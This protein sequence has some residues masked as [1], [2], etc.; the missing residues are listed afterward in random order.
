[1]AG[2]SCQ[3][4]GMPSGMYPLC[5]EHLI[6]KSAGKVIKDKG[7]KWKMQEIIE[8][9]ICI[10]CEN[11]AYGKPLCVD[12][13]KESMDRRDEFDKNQKSYELRDYYFNLRSSIYRITNFE[14]IK[15]N[16]KKLFALAYL[17]HEIH[18]D[19]SLID[20]VIGDVKNIVEKK[21]PQKNIVLTSYS[22]QSDS[23]KSYIIRT[24]DGHIVKSRGENIIDD[25]LYNHNICHCY[26]KDVLEI[27]SKERTLKADW[28]I[29]VRGNQGIYIEY[30]GMDT[31]DYIKNKC[32]KIKIY[33]EYEISLIEVEKDDINDVSGLATRLFREIRTKE[34][35]ILAKKY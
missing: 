3:I 16:C 2:K 20:R 29:P 5:K 22:E 19:H 26:D 13:Y 21:K 34:K 27:D 4:C 14:Y 24:I 33:Q 11:T 8:S 6:M 9:T 1:M 18:K 32:E 12:C 31:G 25:I 35:E 23:Q 17:V 28:F 15:N 7:G 30:W 10:I